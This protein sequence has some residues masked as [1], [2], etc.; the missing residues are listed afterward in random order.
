MVVSNGSGDVVNNLGGAGFAGHLGDGVNSGGTVN[1]GDDVAS[2]NRGNYFFDDGNINAMFGFDLSAGSLNGLGDGLRDGIS[3]GSGGGESSMS[4][5]GNTVSEGKTSKD[6]SISFSFGFT[7]D[8]KSS[9]SDD[10]SAVFVDNLFASL[11]VGDF[12]GDNISGGADV[13]GTG[14]T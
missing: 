14:S 3:Y 11:F 1:L 13:F 6:L 10:S 5:R 4:I 12:L 7:F 2:L 8:D 9:V